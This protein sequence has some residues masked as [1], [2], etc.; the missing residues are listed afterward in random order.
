MEARLRESRGAERTLQ[1]ELRSAR[2]KLQQASGAADGLQAR[3]DGACGQVHG[4]EREL[5]QA[6]HARRDTQ[7]QLD[8]LWAT[9][10]RELGLRPQS[11]CARPERPG[12]PRK[13][14]CPRR[15]R[16]LPSRLRTRPGHPPPPR[17]SRAAP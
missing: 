2:R 5:A 17:A 15:L 10:R 1:A 6:E 8:R 4:L 3:P 12:S 13:G 11:P 7:A 14:Q 9:L 16:G